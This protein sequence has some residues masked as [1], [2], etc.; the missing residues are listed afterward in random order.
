MLFGERIS[1]IR[2]AKVGPKAKLGWRTVQSTRRG[3]QIGSGSLL[4]CRFA[5]DR[6]DAKI[7]I[8]DRCFVGKSLLVAAESITLEDDVIVSWGVTIVDHN[9]HPLSPEVRSADVGQW[10]EGAKDWSQVAM[11]PVRLKRGCWVGFNAVILKGVQIGEGSIV[12]AGSVVTHDVPDRTVVAGNPA[13][14]IRSLS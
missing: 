10:V 6:S 4:Q 9:S 8:G 11:S 12:G 2:G 13:K 1:R 14:V 5:L 7:T 3:I